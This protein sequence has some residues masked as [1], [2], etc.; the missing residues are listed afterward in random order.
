M[1]ADK[2]EDAYLIYDFEFN[3]VL[4]FINHCYG[5]MLKEYEG[6]S[7]E[8]NENKI[9]NRLYKDFLSSNTVRSEIDLFP[10]R[11]ECECAEI[12]DEYEEIG[13]SDI[14]VLTSTSLIN[15]EAYYIIECKRLD[16]S[17][18]LNREYVKEGIYRFIDNKKY[19]SYRNLSGMIGFIVKKVNVTDTVAAINIVLSKEKRINTFE[20]LKTLDNNLYSSSH[21]KFDKSTLT[22][23]H[24]MFDFSDNIKNLTIKTNE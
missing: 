18:S 4:D 15:N 22:I 6:Q 13:Y 12:N 1:N 7:I 14:K 17:T 9:R 5:L 24:L 2:F 8:N 19:P 20:M 3:N 23:R 21:E 10:C 16:G 11:F